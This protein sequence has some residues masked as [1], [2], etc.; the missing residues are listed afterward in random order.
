MPRQFRWQDHCFEPLQVCC[1]FAIEMRPQFT[2]FSAAGITSAT[3]SV[4]QVLFI[5]RQMTVVGV[6]YIDE[7]VG[8][9]FSYGTVNVESTFEAAPPVWQAFQ[10]LF[11]S[12][13]FSKYRS[14][15]S[16]I[17]TTLWGLGIDHVSRF[18][19]GTESYGGHY[20][21]EFITYFDQQNQAIKTGTLVGEQITVSA[22]MI[23]K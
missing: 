23:N 8:T 12:P 18:I 2:A 5:T 13:Q 3:V 20:G 15:E 22:L 1:E 19:F 9:G 6:I 10:I 14:R 17:S 16:V 4:W 11:E 21:P 7:P